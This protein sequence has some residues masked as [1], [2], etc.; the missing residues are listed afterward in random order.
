MVDKNLVRT[1]SKIN[2][3]INF[4]YSRSF[5]LTLLIQINNKLFFKKPLLDLYIVK[6]STNLLQFF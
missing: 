2:I 4:A 5:Q 1:N 3:Y 6:F